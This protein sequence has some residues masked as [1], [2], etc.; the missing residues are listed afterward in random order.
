MPDMSAV[1]CVCDGLKSIKCTGSKS[2]EEHLRTRASVYLMIWLL[3]STLLDLCTSLK[4][5]NSI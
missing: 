5:E 3:P 1:G 2:A 4:S